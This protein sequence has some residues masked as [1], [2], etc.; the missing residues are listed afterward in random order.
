[1]W[2]LQTRK[3][4]DAPGGR[5]CRLGGGIPPSVE[6]QN[7]GG[8]EEGATGRVG[9]ERPGAKDGGLPGLEV[10]VFIA[11]LPHDAACVVEEG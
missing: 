6:D 1:M 10:D 2:S 9:R 11:L 3:F 4:S 5:A 8:A 7:V